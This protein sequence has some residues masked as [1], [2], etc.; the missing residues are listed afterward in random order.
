MPLTLEWLH[1]IQRWQDA[2]WQCCYLPLD[3]VAL[4]GHTTFD[5]LTYEQAIQRDFSPTQPG[6]VW[7]Q[8]W[9]YGWFRGALTLPP[10]AA[11]QRIVL[12]ARQGFE[13]LVWMEDRVVGSFGPAHTEITLSRSGKPGQAYEFVM[14]AYAGHPAVMATGPLPFGVPK[15]SDGGS[16]H[17]ILDESTFGIWLEEVYQLAVD[18]TTLYEL[19]AGL[20][21][22]SLRVAEV[23]RGLMD[24]TLIVDPELP[25]DELVESARQ[26]RARLK[27]LLDCTNGSTAPVL[28]GFGNAHIDVAWLWPLAETNNKM[29]RTVINQLALIEEYPGYRF[30]QSSPELCERLKQHYPELYARFKTAVAAGRILLD[31]AMWLEADTNVSGG[32]ALVRQVMLGRRYFKE[33]YG[34]DSRVLW[35]PD[36]FGYSGALPQILRGCGCVGFATQKITW[37]YN[38]GEPFPYNT[39]HWE[40]I[41]GTAIPAHIYTDYTSP[42]RP[43]ALFSRWNTRLQANGIHSMILAFGW[44]DGGGGPDRNHIEFLRRAADLEGLPRIK[45]S[46]PAEFFAGLEQDG[47]PVERYV[48]ELYFQAH[49]GTF[50]TQAKTKQGMRRAEFSLREAELWGV[51]AR[52]LRGFDFSPATLSEPWHKVL[53]NQF[54][55]ILPGSCIE[56]VKLEAEADLA[57]AVTAAQSAA[58]KAAAALLDDP[59]SGFTVFNSLP[60]ERRELVEAGGQPVEVIVPPCGWATIQPGTLAQLPDERGPARAGH[61]GENGGYVLENDL[62]QAKFNPRGEIVSL[63]DT[64]S[65]RQF[66]AGPASQ[67]RLFKDIPDFWDAWDIASMAEQQPVTI[68]EPVKIEIVQSGPLVAQLKLT[69]KLHNSSLTQVISLRRASR[70]LEFATT[71]DWHEDHK[72]LKVAFPCAIHTSEVISEIQFGHLRRPTHRSHV[73]DADRFEICNHKWS[74][75]AEETASLA[76][77]NDCKYGLSALGNT[78]SLTLLKSSIAPDPTADRGLQTFTYALVPW[79]GSLAESGVVREAYELNAPVLVLPGAAG[80]RSLFNLDAPNIVIESVKPAEDGSP[81]VVLRLYESM[82]AATCCTLTTSLPV[83]KAFEADMMENPL[84]E[85]AAGTAGK[86][87][88]EFRP[89]EIKTVI[90][91]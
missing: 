23:D 10:Q 60:W 80:E 81:A 19:R 52:A 65:G 40:G 88:L 17:Y 76:V 32:E 78:I 73:F 54:H 58:Q 31:G 91:R 42:T 79:I 68:D 57:E 62:L 7:G 44:G 25:M 83:Q 20:D 12:R 9:K 70:R 33:E 69:R 2:L 27:P 46:S 5:H 28:H 36:V 18:F 74:A 56:R 71:V 21:P 6:A 43:S 11:G 85:L 22:L 16:E 89:F 50:T 61:L 15:R 47:L 84:G 67:F 72:L 63:V 59:A 4:S 26:A 82:R 1:R 38:G 14:E 39:F 37:N 8:P 3:N 64:L 13:S 51:A 77:L 48:G 53:L 24:A 55:D 49:R 30:L 29:A 35:L 34:V 66:M 87:P 41:D 45:N 90:L 86:I 75:L